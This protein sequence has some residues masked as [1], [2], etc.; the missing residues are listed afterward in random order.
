ME[1]AD[2]VSSSAGTADIAVLKVPATAPVSEHLGS[3][4]LNPGGPGAS[5]VAYREG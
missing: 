5:P 2:L 3:I 4:F 1:R